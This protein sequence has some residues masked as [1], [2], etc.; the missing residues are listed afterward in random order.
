MGDAL[1]KRGV[2]ADLDTID[3]VDGPAKPPSAQAGLDTIDG[4]E[5]PTP[6]PSGELASGD[7]Y[8]E[9]PVVE[10]RHYKTTGE[11]AKGGIGRVFEARDRRLGRAVAIKELLPQNRD[12]ARRFER[13]ARI[14]ARL[15]HPAII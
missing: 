2:Q 1:G 13:E 11:I 15:Q 3:G 14:T 7:D 8:P 10:R 4:R 9:L 6:A 12:I 5:G